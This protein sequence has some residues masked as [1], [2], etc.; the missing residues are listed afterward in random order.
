MIPS[1]CPLHCLSDVFD[2]VHVEGML[3]PPS[4]VIRRGFSS[5]DSAAAGMVATLTHFLTFQPSDIIRVLV[6]EFWG[7]LVALL[8]WL[9]SMYCVFKCLHRLDFRQCIKF[10]LCNK[11]TLSVF[12]CHYWSMCLSVH[13]PQEATQR[14]DVP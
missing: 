6:R 1:C 10:C 12:V 5:F 14:G 4:R 3:R 8:F 7:K 2:L 11:G 13:G 9:I